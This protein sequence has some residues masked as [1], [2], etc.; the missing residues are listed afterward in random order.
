MRLTANFAFSPRGSNY[1]RCDGFNAPL[2]RVAIT[3]MYVTKM[4][5]NLNCT[6]I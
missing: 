6:K 4:F 2:L 5:V 3:C 1:I